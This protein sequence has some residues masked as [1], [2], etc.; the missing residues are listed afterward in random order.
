MRP[1]VAMLTALSLFGIF[2]LVGSVPLAIRATRRVSRYRQ[3]QAWPKVRATLTRSFVREGTAGDDMSHLPEFAFRYSVAGVEY[4]SGL[5]TEGTP[6]PGSKDDIREMLKRFPF[7]SVVQ[8]AVNLPTHAVRSS[9]PGSRRPGASC[10]VRVWWPSWS[11]ARSPS[12]GDPREVT[13]TAG[14]ERES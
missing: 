4:S 7:G 8:V 14:I 11:A 13:R 5:H 2:L 12:P 9:T 10:S 6:F 1:S 3:S